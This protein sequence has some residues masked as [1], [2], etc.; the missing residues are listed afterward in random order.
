VAL[1]RDPVQSLG[2]AENIRRDGAIT[3]LDGREP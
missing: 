1:E 3:L 2:H